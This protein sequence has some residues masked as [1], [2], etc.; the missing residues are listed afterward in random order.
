MENLRNITNKFSTNNDTEATNNCVIMEEHELEND[1]FRR[2]REIN[3]I[4]I[5][6]TIEFKLLF[7]LE[8]LINI[9]AISITS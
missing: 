8:K 6:F 2:R 1:L 7:K 9:F 5:F 4:F 3:V